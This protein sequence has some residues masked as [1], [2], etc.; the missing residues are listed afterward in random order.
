MSALRALAG[1]ARLV[2]GPSQPDDYNYEHFRAKHL[3]RDAMAMASG[4]GVKPGERAPDFK[5]PK[6][7]GGKLRLSDFRGQPVLLRFVSYT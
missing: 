3:L 1:V 2:K 5:L 4:A 7:A 6:A